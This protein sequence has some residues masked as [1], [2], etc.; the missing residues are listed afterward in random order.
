MR[1][2][3]RIPSRPGHAP[4]RS[5]RVLAAIATLAFALAG[6]GGGGDAG[7]PAAFDVTA[8]VGG[9]PQ[10]VIVP[11]APVNIAMQA[12]QSIELDAN[13]PV[14]WLFTVGGSPLFASGITVV[15][16]GISITQTA[17]SPSRVAIDTAIVS[18]VITPL[19]VTLTA[20]STIDAAQVATVNLLID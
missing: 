1:Q 12:G 20:T 8:I 14:E 3:I 17:L 10:P 11:G 16:G 9:Q 4:I 5:A 18:P 19:A 13:E 6:C 15:S 7:P 2:D